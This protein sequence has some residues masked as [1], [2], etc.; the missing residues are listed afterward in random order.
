[1]RSQRTDRSRAGEGPLRATDVRALFERGYSLSS[2][3]FLAM[4]GRATPDSV[5]VNAYIIPQPPAPV[6]PSGR[7]IQRQC[8]AG[9]FGSRDS[10][11]TSVGRTTQL[12]T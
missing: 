8:P 3:R 4:L 7:I 1:M 12:T 9:A 10:D 5:K 6:N 2:R 11:V